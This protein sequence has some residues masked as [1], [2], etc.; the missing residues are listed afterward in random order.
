MAG[1]FHKHLVRVL[2]AHKP[3]QDELDK[4]RRV[5]TEIKDHKNLRKI[6]K[7]QVRIY[8]GGSYKKRTMIA[9]SYDLDMVIYYP[10]KSKCSPKEIFCEVK[11]ALE[12][13]GHKIEK[14]RG[15]ALQFEYKG[16]DI[17]I[18]P[19]KAIDNDFVFAN[20]Y[21]VAR[22]KKQRTSLKE[23]IEYIKSVRPI[24][25]LM[26]IWRKWHGLQWH[27]TAM[28]QI[29]VNILKNE[30]KNDYGVCLEHIF[31]DIKSS[32]S[33]VKFFDPTNSNNPIRVSK[34]EREKIQ[35]AA[36]SSYNAI[37]QGRYKKVIQ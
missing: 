24:I 30:R 21:N 26:K 11:E 7:Q 29:I 5:F 22:D 8:Y 18:V 25:K 10:Q 14:P 36:E 6:R 34:K 9:D 17:D 27:K 23:Q 16:Y 2:A 19:A 31:L 28:D 13:A 15:V 37:K 1:D 12:G 33:R 35:Q 32:G 3:S 4:L 20:A